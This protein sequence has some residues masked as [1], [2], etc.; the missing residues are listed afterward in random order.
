MQQRGEEQQDSIAVL[1]G[2]FY[3]GISRLSLGEFNAAHALFERCYEL[4]DASLRQA[5]SPILAED[6]YSVMLGYSSV[7]LAY[8]GYLD[9]AQTRAD[10]GVLEARRLR[11][12]Y[13]LA[14]CLSFKCWTSYI[15]NMMHE[16]RQHADE[17][18]DLANEHGFPLWAASATFYRGL[19][20]TADGASEGVT[21]M[22]RARD[23]NCAMGQVLFSPYNLTCIAESY[24]KLGQPAEGLRT[25]RD[26]EQLV[27]TTD[28]RHHQ[29]EVNRLQGDLLRMI[30]DHPAAERSYHRALAVAN[31][32]NART[33]ELRAA[34]SMAR[35][36]RDQG[37]REEARELLAPVYGWFTEGFDTPNL[38][39]AKALLD[40]LT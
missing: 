30:D 13:T 36:W 33:H 32:Q 31:R 37:K 19:W 2:R 29:A 14:F 26:A 38:K 27:E 28:E 35:L 3:E 11:H 1:L 5:V 16:V 20:L 4:R 40:E 25:L 10:E 18:S 6:S 34:T 39:D 24:G 21:L 9:Q 12:F 23:Q 15:A 7:N 17:I 8:L 22:L